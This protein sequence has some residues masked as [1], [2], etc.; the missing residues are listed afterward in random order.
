[1]RLIEDMD[2]NI[3]TNEEDVLR[4]WKKYFEELLN[5]EKERER[6]KEEP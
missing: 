3:I 4:R 5:D 1:M 2:G 6:R